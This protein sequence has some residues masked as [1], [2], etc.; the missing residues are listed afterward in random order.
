[1]IQL[2]KWVKNNP[3]RAMF[4]LPIILVAIISISHVVT[5]YDLTNPLSW[6]IYLSVAIEIAAMTALVAATNKIQGGIWLMFGLVTFIQIIGNVF[7]CYKE[8]DETSELFLSWLELTSPVW[9]M[10]GSDVTDII[11]MKRWLAFLEGGLLP[12]ISLTSLHFFVHYDKKEEEKKKI[13][14][15]SVKEYFETRNEKVTEETIKNEE[16]TNSIDNIEEESILTTPVEESPPPSIINEVG[17][18]EKIVTT[19]DLN[20]QAI[21]PEG[22]EFNT[23]YP[24]SDVMEIPKEEEIIDKEVEET[25]EVEKTNVK[26][27]NRRR[28]APPGSKLMGGNLNAKNKRKPR[29]D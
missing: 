15:E 26:P 29:V 9:D 23:P 28:M 2:W 19:T 13:S 27:K 25:K 6:A 5:W 11:S 22:K 3:N 16:N 24:L 18:D 10:M 7:F 1:M 20:F 8:I 12:V 21:V 17:E 4:L 14:E